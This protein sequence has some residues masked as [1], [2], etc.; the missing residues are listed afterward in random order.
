MSDPADDG[1]R[2]AQLKALV[3]EVQGAINE[4]GGRYQIEREVTALD[5]RHDG[6]ACRHTIPQLAL[7]VFKPV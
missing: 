5:I 7:S 1:E 2:I 3:R 4:L 6:R